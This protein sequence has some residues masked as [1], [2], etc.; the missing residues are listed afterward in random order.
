M[1]S[2][3]TTPAAED[4]DDA[5]EGGH[6]ATEREAEDA[7]ERSAG[8]GGEE[9]RSGAAR[10]RQRGCSVRHSSSQSRAALPARIQFSITGR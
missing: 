8:D 3:T 10:C 1:L 6:P 7:E 5:G 9:G 4:V 2:G